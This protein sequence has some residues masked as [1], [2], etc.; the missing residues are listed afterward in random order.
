[1]LMGMQKKLQ[2]L[3]ALFLFVSPI[4]AE[5]QW[6]NVGPPSFTPNQADFPGISLDANGI[7]Y[8]VFRDQGAGAKASVMNYNGSSWNFIGNRG[9]S[10]GDAYTPRLCFNHLQ[11]PFIAYMDRTDS[12]KA[13]VMRFA[14]NVWKLVGSRG[15]TKSAASFE[16]IVIDAY[17]T[18]YVA[19]R[20]L[21]HDYRASVM[22]FDGNDWDY[23]GAPAFSPV[24]N[25]Y[26]GAAYTTLSFDRNGTLYISF[27]DVVNNFLATVM[28]F[29][30]SG[31]VYVGNPGFASWNADYTNALAF[32]SQNTPYLVCSAG[33]KAAV[34]KFDGTNCVF[35]GQAGFSP[36]AVDFASLV[37]DQNTNTPYV[38]LAMYQW[39]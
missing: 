37:I 34:K 16:S 35:L 28:K 12:N 23:V 4:L 26:D 31:W 15:F 32:D 10:D 39:T 18:P 24:G 8:L 38:T 29:D 3:S 7:P 19:F 25:G 11:N 14:G 21:Y 9:I 17:G 2:F 27:C 22:K 36:G 20:D 30:G 6:I 1:M 5:A 13:T 33:G